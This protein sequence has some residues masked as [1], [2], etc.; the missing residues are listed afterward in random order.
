[1]ILEILFLLFGISLGVV[2][3]LIPGLHPN[4]LFT[5]ILSTSFLVLTY[6]FHLILIFIVSLS[7]TNTIT[8]FIPSIFFGAPDPS[9]ALSVLPAHEMLM[10]GRGYEALYLTAIG[11]IGATIITA[12]TLPLLLII[13]PSLYLSIK[14]YLHIILLIVV[15]MM[16]LFE[17]KKL[18]AI[19]IFILT[20]MFGF[21]SLN[22][23]SSNIIFPALTGLFGLSTLLG[24]FLTNTKIPEQII[25]K[26]KTSKKGVI[27]G[28]FAGLLAGILPGIGSAQAGIIAGSVLKTKTKDFLTSLGGIN[29]SN[30]IFTFITLFTLNK[31]RS[32]ASWIISQI[33]LLNLQDLI[34]GIITAVISS[35]FAVIITLKLGKMIVKRIGIIDYKKMNFAVIVFLFILVFIFTS[36]L[37]LFI[38]VLG[39]FIGMLTISLGVKRSHLMSFLLFPTI[40]YFSGLTPVLMNLIF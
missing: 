13:L 15:M 28:W 7:V 20:G 1:M 9:S 32:G 16:L 22:S 36:F 3:G 33:S 19:F 24:S 11:G 14:N 8:D 37:G 18:A 25:T 31:T 29:T 6:P 40:L 5:L 12:I 26:S 27:T 17:R 30:I 38:S 4:T 2:T 34:N 10:K 21:I 23:F 35:L 39:M